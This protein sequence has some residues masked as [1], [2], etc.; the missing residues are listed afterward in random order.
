MEQVVN[1]GNNIWIINV[2]IVFLILTCSGPSSLIK[3]M[4]FYFSS[5]YAW[6][7]IIRMAIPWSSSPSSLADEPPLSCPSFISS[8]PSAGHSD[9]CLQII[10]IEFPFQFAQPFPYNSRTAI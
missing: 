3:F 1:F 5:L 10:S 7:R 2:E 9:I 8:A 6:A 4:N